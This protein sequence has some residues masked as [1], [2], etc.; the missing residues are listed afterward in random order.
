MRALPLFLLAA[1]AGCG[2]PPP[3]AADLDAL[4]RDLVGAGDPALATALRQPIMV[5]P[6]LTQSSNARAVRPAP[7]IDTG[8]MPPDDLG[9][10]A[11]TS[12]AADLRPTPAAT[13]GCP[14]CRAAKGALTLGTLAERQPGRGIAACA[15]LIRYAT[16]WADRLPPALPLYPDALVAEAAGTDAGGCR[17]RAVTFS[18]AA[19]PARV[20]D[21]FGAHATRGGFAVEHRADGAEHMVAGTRGGGGFVL[22][23]RPRGNGG[24][25]ADLVSNVGD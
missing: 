2:K 6:G 5:D 18:S 24:S 9:R 20:G 22:F 16:G 11:D 1:L 19:A 3:A 14:G 15:P 17:L 21:W 4:D 12:R 10:P 8:A 13:P 25:E 23:V 7:S